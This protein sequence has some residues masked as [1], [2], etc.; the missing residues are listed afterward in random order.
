M[1]SM[2]YLVGEVM[3]TAVARVRPETPV[4]QVAQLLRERGVTAVPVV[5]EEDHILGVVSAMG[6]TLEDGPPHYPPALLE[7]M[8]RHPARATGAKTAAGWMSSPVVSVTPEVSLR[9]A[10]LLLQ[11]HGIHHL[12]VVADGKLVGMV[13]RRDLLA[14]FLRADDQARRQIVGRSSGA[15]SRVSWDGLRRPRTA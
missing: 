5:D 15:A 11:T 13:T 9:T 12:P 7:C 2:P 8:A 10:A 6:L 4:T 14:A 3:T 1:I